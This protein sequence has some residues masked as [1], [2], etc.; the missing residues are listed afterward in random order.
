MQIIAPKLFLYSRYEEC[1]L[2]NKG[3]VEARNTGN[4]YE[5]ASGKSD[6]LGLRYEGVIFPQAISQIGGL[7]RDVIA[8]GADATRFDLTMKSD[9]NSLPFSHNS[10]MKQIIVSKE[11][12]DQEYRVLLE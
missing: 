12:K 5:A 6:K 4:K 3:T 2:T 9:E 7:C 11:Y 10:N 8:S 1:N